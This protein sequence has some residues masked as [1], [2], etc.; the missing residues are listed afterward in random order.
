MAERIGRLQQAL[1]DDGIEAYVITKGSDTRYLTGFTGDYETS[2]FVVAPAGCWFV[3]DGRYETQAAEEVGDLAEVRLY[4]R[5]GTEHVNYYTC[6]GDIL[7]EIGVERAGYVPEDITVADYNDLAAHAEGVALEP[8]EDHVAPLRM[9][10]DADEIETIRHACQISMRSFY[11]LLDTI[12]PGVTEFDVANELERQFRSRGGECSC[13]ETIVAS[14]PYN[15][16]CPHATVSDRVLE[17]GDFVTIDFG[18]RYHGYCSDIT[19]TV[20]IGRAR[21]PELY[22]YWKIV[23]EAKEIGASMLRPG[24]TYAEVSNAVHAHVNKFGYTIPHGVGHN[25]GLDI[26]EAPFMGPLSDV[27]ERPGMIHTVEPG[28]Y[29]PGIGGVRQED[30]YLI[31]EDGCERLS[32]I[33]DHLI[34]L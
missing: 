23:E 20:V 2:V 5:W 26:H 1:K 22:R 16:A 33:T 19:R 8:V 17:Y 18:A 13:F 12:R 4:H 14:G 24:V 29:V 25:F 10:K 3:T 30:D 11:A 27:P 28:I 15:G 6:A 32:Y 21:E 9:I 31:T 34:E 7:H